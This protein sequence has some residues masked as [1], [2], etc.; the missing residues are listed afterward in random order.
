MVGVFGWQSTT[1][2]PEFPE[3]VTLAGTAIHG[4]RRRAGVKS[5][6]VVYDVVV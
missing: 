2:G 4:Y 5:R 6:D 1:Y 3:R